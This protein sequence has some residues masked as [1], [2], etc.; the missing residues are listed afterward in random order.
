MGK[1]AT[2]IGL[3]PLLVTSCLADSWPLVT[4]RHSTE[5]TCA[6]E[7]M[8][9]ITAIDARHRGCW[10][11]YWLG[12]SVAC[13]LEEMTRRARQVGDFAPLCAAAGIELGFQ[14]VTTL[15]HGFSE[16]GVNGYPLPDD[17]FQVD[18][19]GRRTRFFLCPRS[20]A[21]LEM[22]ERFA[23]T[24]VREGKLASW[25]LDD[26]LRFGFYKK[27]AAA[28]FCPR[29]LADFNAAAGTHLTREELI[30]RLDAETDDEPLRAKWAAFKAESLALFAAAARRG[31]VRANPSIRLGY[32][33]I[34]SASIVSGEDYLPILRALSDGGKRPVGIRPG[35][36][37]Y[38]ELDASPRWEMPRKLLDVAREAERCHAAAGL[39]VRVVYEQENYP[40]LV[41]YK[42]PEAALK[43]AAMA[44]AFG[45]DGVSL[46]WYDERCPEPLEH[47]EDFARLAAAW[48]PYLA[49]L[50]AVCRG[51]R[52]AGVATARDEKLMTGRANTVKAALANALPRR[53]DAALLAQQLGIPVTVAEGAAEAVLA[54]DDL[55]SAE[56]SSAQRTRL[57]D[58]LDGR[59]PCPL[60]VRIDKLHPLLVAARV[61][62]AGRTVAVTLL[63]LSIGRAQ[64]VR[65]R[66]RRPAGSSATLLAP[67]AAERPLSVEKGGSDE[68]VV[69]LPDLGA[70]ELATVVFGFKIHYWSA[71]T[72][73]RISSALRE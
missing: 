59:G 2:L 26:D 37:Y 58:A 69:A 43:E 1:I 4:M 23:E 11:E 3:G 17:A 68:L 65:V 71:D 53:T 66:V 31:A 45:C 49:R 51:T 10:D 39:D 57:L 33:A 14:Q 61:D 7:R 5:T 9:E 22:E 67:C 6:P 54:P 40:R 38:R 41:V 52:L 16:L 44:L 47:Y 50:Q 15:G 32:Q 48:R 70:W 13:K 62:G 27:R 63:N 21:V 29:C 42:S 73:G 46:Y 18:A 28:C 24:Y 8:R 64:G 72:V 56:V 35:H 12:E 55:E 34:S 25:W 30:A 19:D 60:C 36:G 20:P